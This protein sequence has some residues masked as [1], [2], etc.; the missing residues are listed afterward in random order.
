M[1]TDREPTYVE[2]SEH[3]TAGQSSHKSEAEEED[4]KE[5]LEDLGYID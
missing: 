5:L 3:R 1:I 4:V 2:L